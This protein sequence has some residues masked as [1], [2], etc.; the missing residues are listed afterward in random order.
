ML[1]ESI[2]HT[3]S[4]ESIWQ[5]FAITRGKTRVFDSSGDL[6]VQVDEVARKF[7]EYTQPGLGVVKEWEVEYAEIKND[8][9]EEHKGVE[10]FGSPILPY[11]VK[12]AIM[13]CKGKSAP[14]PDGMHYG[15][16]KK[17]PLCGVQLMTKMFNIQ[18]GYN[19]HSGKYLKKMCK[20]IFIPDIFE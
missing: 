10:L 4:R 3:D 12:S 2:E 8:M 7:K 6:A 19:T 11:E 17:L 5:K 16:Y 15:I 20:K 18:A 14:G 1:V 13:K 9:Q